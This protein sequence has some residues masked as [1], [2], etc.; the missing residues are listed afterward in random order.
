MTTAPTHGIRARPAPG[1]FREA[2]GHLQVGR[3]PSACVHESSAST[4]LPASN[5]TMSSSLSPTPTNLMGR[6]S[7]SAIPMT[8]PPLAVPSSLVRKM[9]VMPENLRNSRAWTTAFWP[10]VASRTRRISWGAPGTSR[11]MTRL[12]LFE[13]VHEVGVGVDPSGRVDEQ[14]VAAFWALKDRRASKT[15]EA[16]SAPYGP[17]TT[18][19]PSRP[20][21]DGTS[22]S[23]A[24]ARNV[25]AAAIMTFRPPSRAWRA[26]LAM[27]VVFP[28]PL[29]PTIMTT[30]GPGPAAN[31]ASIPDEEGHD[32]VPEGFLQDVGGGVLA[33]LCPDG[34]DDLV[35][36]G[37][38]RHRPGSWL[39]RGRPGPRPGSSRSGRGP[40]TSGKPAW[41]WRVFP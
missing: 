28:P 9:P 22:C 39:R 23:W 7:S 6:P 14:E 37:R 24:A 27:D 30:D 25:S 29:T 2:V 35:G 16:G 18:G 4:K 41:S 19:M 38:H 17:V 40:R 15:T 13:L 12:D 33:R 10:I 32:L 20:S 34:L 11:A 21:P 36:R 31:G 26:S 1:L 8:V 5:S 3:D